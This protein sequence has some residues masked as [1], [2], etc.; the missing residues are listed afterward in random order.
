[1]NGNKPKGVIRQRRRRRRRTTTTRSRRRKRRRRRRRRKE[2]KNI[3]S[4]ATRFKY[5]QFSICI[6]Q[7]RYYIVFTF[8]P[9]APTWSISLKRCFTSVS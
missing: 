3:H 7:R 5:Q 6:Y 9:V 2:E 1:M 4:P 8:I